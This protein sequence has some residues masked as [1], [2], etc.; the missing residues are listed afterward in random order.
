MS[1]EH[2]ESMSADIIDLEAYRDFGEIGSK[3]RSEIADETI[4]RIHE[5]A[6]QEKEQRRLE[7][8]SRVKD[9]GSY[10]FARVIRDGRMTEGV[11]TGKEPLGAIVDATEEFLARPVGSFFA[12][13]EME[14]ILS[15]A[16]NE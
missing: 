7:I 2:D 4:E 10:R 15:E 1:S 5:W 14:S 12:E 9:V 11:S 13:G 6:R 3:T 8:A 16:M